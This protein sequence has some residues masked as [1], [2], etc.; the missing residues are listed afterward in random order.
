[1]STGEA[2]E[3]GRNNTVEMRGLGKEVY[4]RRCIGC[5]GEKGDGNGP[6]A[7]FLQ[8]KPR[9]FTKGIF[10]FHSTQGDNPLPTDGDLYVTISHG[11]WGTAMPPW[12]GI[13]SQ[14]RIAVIQY[15][16]TFSNRW[17]TEE[18]PAV[19]VV[20]PEPPAT[21]ASVQKGKEM[22]MACT[23]CHGDSGKGDGPLAPALTNI[24]NLPITPANF[25]LPAGA[26]G[27]VKLGHDGPH[28]YKT[29]MNGIGGGPM[30]AFFGS[31]KPQDTWAVVHYIQSLRID[32]HVRELKDAGMQDA[33]EKS[34]RTRLWAELSPA[35][36][37]GRIDT[38]L[39]EPQTQARIAINSG[40]PHE[41]TAQG[42][43]R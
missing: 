24:W 14:D 40:T 22:F 37:K 21:V 3:S 12:Y 1:L 34:A 25:T 11:L 23:P 27:G 28:L 29:I 35:A 38:A 43:I 20:P 19:V 41:Q 8:T 13:S 15:I 39:L 33:D 9:D 5:H 30:P 6:A 31:L 17:Q 36:E 26:P 16:K 18:V 42:K 4:G 7:A 32:T 2:L 10:K